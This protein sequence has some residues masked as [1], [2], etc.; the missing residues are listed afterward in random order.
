[1]NPKP[2]ID[3]S[4]SSTPSSSC[5]RDKMSRALVIVALVLMI[6]G[7]I[8]LAMT[9]LGSIGDSH[10]SG[11]QIGLWIHQGLG[12]LALSIQ[13]VV[14]MPVILIFGYRM[15]RH[16]ERSLARK[17]RIGAIVCLVVSLGVYVAGCLPYPN[18]R[19]FLLFGRW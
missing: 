6:F 5:P 16:G 4:G 3:Y 15:A 14:L 7:G 1:M 10:Q 2:I 12:G 8:V 13:W 11:E 19:Y 18:D 17:Y 9:C